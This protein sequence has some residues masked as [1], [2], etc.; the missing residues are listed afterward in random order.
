MFDFKKV[1]ELMESDE[2][3]ILDREVGIG[4]WEWGVKNNFFL[5]NSSY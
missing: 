3:K 2:W 5:I 1:C 4:I